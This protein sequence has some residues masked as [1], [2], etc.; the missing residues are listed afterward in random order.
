MRFLRNFLIRRFV[1]YILLVTSCLIVIAGAGGA[2]VLYKSENHTAHAASLFQQLITLSRATLQPYGSKEQAALISRLPADP[3]GQALRAAEKQSSGE[4]T[5]AALERLAWLEEQ[6]ETDEAYIRLSRQ[7]L[8]EIFIATLLAVLALLVFC[9]RYLVAHL[10]RPIDDI[11]NHLRVITGGDLTAEPQDLGRNCVGQL[12]PL[13]KNMQDSLLTTV[14][15]IRESTQ[16]VYREAEAIAEG[17]SDLSQRTMSQAA[18]LEETAASMEQLSSSVSLNASS[19]GDASR[20]AEQT[21]QTTRNGASLVKAASLAMNTLE[22]AADRIHEFISTINSIAFQT[23]ILSLNA[24]VEA[25]RAGEQGKGFAVVASEVRMLA[26]RSAGAA[27]EIEGLI[28]ETMLRISEGRQMTGGA[29]DAMEDIL[30]RVESVNTLLG[31]ISLASSEQSN[32]ISQVTSAVA[33]LDRA[34]QQNSTL[35]QTVMAS[36]ET[37]RNQTVVL[38]EVIMRFRLPDRSGSDAA[39]LQ[40]NSADMHRY[41]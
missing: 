9:D 30:Q 20:L 28:N 3:D 5:R 29:G 12:V 36:A 21:T 38:S 24:A 4:F 39:N 34:T 33:E 35:V 16:A 7:K 1:M 6:H 11:R 37:L 8:E 2:V 25:A 15:A 10:V 23:N 31:Q 19:A 17:N 40:V 32:G 26:Q 14:L 22:E 18:A 27:K 41:S 13:I